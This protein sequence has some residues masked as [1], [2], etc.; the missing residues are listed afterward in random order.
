MSPGIPP[1]KH[2]HVY[3]MGI[4]VLEK[5]TKK[6]IYIENDSAF[7]YITLDQ[8]KYWIIH[9]QIKWNTVQYISTVYILETALFTSVCKGCGVEV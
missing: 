2:F 7:K 4:D 9:H 6:Y 8:Q 5:I 3:C 1:L